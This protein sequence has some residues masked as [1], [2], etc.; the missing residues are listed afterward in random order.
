MTKNKCSCGVLRK[1][2]WKEG[3]FIHTSKCL[4]DKSRKRSINPKKEKKKNVK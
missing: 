3:E 1:Y 2:H 4:V